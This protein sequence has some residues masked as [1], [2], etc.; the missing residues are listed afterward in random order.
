MKKD[1]I[2]KSKIEMKD[3]EMKEESKNMPNGLITFNP[4]IV[5]GGL[6]IGILGWFI[7]GPIGAIIGFI[8]GGIIGLLTRFLGV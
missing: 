6:L 1:I 8:V 5:A 4:R 2:E 3:I 7:A